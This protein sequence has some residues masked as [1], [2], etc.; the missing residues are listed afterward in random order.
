MLPGEPRSK[1]VEAMRGISGPGEE[2]Q[3][4]ARAASI[5]NFKLNTLFDGDQLDFMRRGVHLGNRMYR[6]QE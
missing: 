6:K 4:S 2:D 5:Q 3:R 1:A